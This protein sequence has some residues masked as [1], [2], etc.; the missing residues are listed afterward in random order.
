MST[1]IIN[2]TIPKNEL[3]PEF[4]S[5]FSPEENYLMIKIGGEC[6]FK[7]RTL[8]AGLSQKEIYNKIK[9]ESKEDIERLEMDVLIERELTKRMEDNISKIYEGQIEQLNKKLE[10]AILQIKS[11]EKDNSF[12]LH[13][14]INKVKVKYDLLLEEKDRQNKLNREVFDKAEKLINK[15]MNKSSISIGDD[16]EQIFENLGEMG[17]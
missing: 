8:I 7:A 9:E 1:K 14:E 10:N 13:E 12:L 15:N 17:L 3:V 2:L 16:G 5:L 4:V 6:L 11:Y